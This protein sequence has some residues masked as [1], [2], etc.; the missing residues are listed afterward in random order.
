[1]NPYRERTEALEI[2]AGSIV[3]AAFVLGVCWLIVAGHPDAAGIIGTLGLA[4]VF[5]T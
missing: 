3:M 2:L 1:M 5:L 4:L